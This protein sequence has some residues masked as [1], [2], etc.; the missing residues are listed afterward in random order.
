MATSS[1][2]RVEHDLIGTIAA[3]ATA[4]Y[5]IHTIMVVEDFRISATRRIFLSARSNQ[6]IR[7]TVERAAG[8]LADERANAII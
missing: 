5:E 6:G 2:L 3:P 4:H 1:P 7:G 8:L